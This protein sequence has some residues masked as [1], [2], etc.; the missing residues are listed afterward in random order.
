MIIADL[1]IIVTAVYSPFHIYI[2]EGQ[3]HLATS[4]H[5]NHPFAHA[6]VCVWSG[7]TGAR[8]GPEWGRH[9]APTFYRTI[10]D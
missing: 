9:L 7:V 10:D 4:S 8:Y 1:N 3:R 5:L 2:V 6:R